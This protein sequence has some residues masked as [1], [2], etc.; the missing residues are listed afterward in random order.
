MYYKK[1]SDII[2]SIEIDY[3]FDN[4]ELKIKKQIQ[5]FMIN[6]YYKHEWT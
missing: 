3:S 6:T 1:N 2:A 4:I 5:E